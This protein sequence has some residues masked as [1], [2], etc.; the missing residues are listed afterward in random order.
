MFFHTL[1]HMVAFLSVL[2]IGWSIHLVS[3]STPHWS[4]IKTLKDDI[5]RQLQSQALWH[6]GG[7][8]PMESL[9]ILQSPFR[10]SKVSTLI[11][12]HWR[13]LGVLAPPLE[14]LALLSSNHFD[15]HELSRV[16]PE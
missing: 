8:R 9:N 7:K 3:L 10:N 16:E 13:Q 15:L 4:E 5:N 6:D 11:A 2:K 14:S 12:R 1:M